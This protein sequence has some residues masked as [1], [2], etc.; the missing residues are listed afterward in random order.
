[1]YGEAF[2]HMKG[3]PPPGGS[4][5][6][7]GGFQGSGPIDLGDIFGGQVDLGDLF[8]GAFGGGKTTGGRGRQRSRRGPD[9]QSEIK[10]PFQLA[11][12]GGNYDISLQRDGKVDR[13]SIKIPAG[14][15]DGGVIR[16]AG[17]G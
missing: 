4:P 6:G 11:A 10:I 12:T 17:Q 15:R 9:V 7:G 14:V 13:L 3:G 16:L 8:G 5:F 1:Q 2:K